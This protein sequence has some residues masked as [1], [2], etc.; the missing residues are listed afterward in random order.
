MR[1][2]NLLFLYSAMVMLVS[3]V[4]VLFTEDLFAAVPNSTLLGLRAALNRLSIHLAAWGF[5]GMMIFGMAYVLVPSFLGKNLAMVSAPKVHLA[6]AL[7]SLVLVILAEARLSTTTW[8]IAS[9][10]WLAGAVLFA[11]NMLATSRR[12]RRP[13]IKRQKPL[14]LGDRAG[15]LLVVVATGYLLASSALFIQ[16]DLERGVG[17][18][19]AMNY[20]AHL[21]LYLLGFVIMM[22]FGVGYHLI[23]RFLAATPHIGLLYANVATAVP[24]PVLMVVFIARGGPGFVIGAALFATAFA[25]FASNV[26]LM[27]I[28]RGRDVQPTF[29][30]ILLALVFFSAGIG[31]GLT[32]AL[33]SPTRYLSPVHAELNL[34]GFVAMTIFGVSYYVFP[35]FPK[36]SDTPSYARPL[37]HMIL[38]ATGLSLAAVAKLH[39]LLSGRGLPWLV[40]FGEALILVSVLIYVSCMH[41]MFQAIWKIAGPGSRPPVRSLDQGA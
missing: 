12:A 10:L 9:A 11:G 30:F 35:Y 8:R 41:T 21:H 5:I 23:P 2:Q 24:A 25:S 39:L 36:G 14:R 1:R 6:L 18:V 32:F 22:V 29:A 3:W 27:F 13:T 28:R 37:A 20:W 19:L 40:V 17:V 4:S 26:V 16:F 38:A 7:S 34:F 31:L 15:V 33:Y